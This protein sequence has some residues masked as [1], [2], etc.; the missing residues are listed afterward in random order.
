MK[1][2][3]LL[4]SGLF[5]ATVNQKWTRFNA[6][7]DDLIAANV[8]TAAS[9]TAIAALRVLVRPLWFKFGREV[10]YADIAVA[11]VS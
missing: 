3:F 6:M 8:I 11:R 2:L 10:D 9:K 1:E 5:N 4:P 7:L